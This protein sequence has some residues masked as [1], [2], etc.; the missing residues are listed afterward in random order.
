[1]FTHPFF[2]QKIVIIKQRDRIEKSCSTKDTI[3]GKKSLISLLALSNEHELIDSLH[4]YF[5]SISDKYPAK[6]WHP[7][8]KIVEEDELIKVVRQW[9]FEA[10]FFKKIPDLAAQ[11][12]IAGFYELLEP[13]IT[14]ASI[15]KLDIAPPVWYGCLWDD[16]VIENELGRFLLG[17]SCTD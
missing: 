10:E 2:I 1:M 6:Y 8:L 16:F 9:F 14:T 12:V 15:Y 3:L 13:F 11:N 7:K 5:L 17:F 4:P